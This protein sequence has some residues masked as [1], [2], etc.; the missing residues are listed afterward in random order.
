MATTLR[1]IVG[2][3]Y[4]ATVRGYGTVEVVRIKRGAWKVRAKGVEVAAGKSLA[5]VT[6]QIDALGSLSPVEGR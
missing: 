3:N 2:G 4:E 1:R 5:D 6:A